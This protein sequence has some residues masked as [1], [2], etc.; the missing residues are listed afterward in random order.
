MYKGKTPVRS[1][2]LITLPYVVMSLTACGSLSVYQPHT[3]EEVRENDA[4][5]R[6][7]GDI[8]TDGGKSRGDILD[9]CSQLMKEEVEAALGRTVMEPT[10]SNEL[11]S[12]RAGTLTS[13]CMFGSDQGFVSVSVRQQSPASATAWDAAR[14]YEELKDLIVK[15]D[16]EKTPVGFEEVSGLGAEAFAETKQEAVNYETTELRVLSKRSILTIRVTAPASIPTL[17]AARMLAAKAISRLEGYESNARDPAPRR[18]R[19][20]RRK[21]SGSSQAENKSA[22]KPER[23]PVARAAKTAP[24]TASARVGKGVSRQAGETGSKLRRESANST[25]ERGKKRPAK[26]ARPTPKNRRRG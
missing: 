17:E 25:A 5:D 21:A 18:D 23:S 7:D 2:L 8:S 22:K 19:D 26:A 11:V 4:G 1:L 16:G 15:G 24:K 12:R 3:G 6:D 20:E 9:A 14:A 10:H 13:S